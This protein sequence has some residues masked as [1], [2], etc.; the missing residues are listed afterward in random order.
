MTTRK[1]HSA[2]HLMV[3]VDRLRALWRV[4]VPSK[5]RDRLRR[6]IQPEEKTCMQD[7]LLSDEG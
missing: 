5:A 1:I 2:E 3:E 7:H 4:Y 6:D